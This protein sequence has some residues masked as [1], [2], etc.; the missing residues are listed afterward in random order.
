MW[1]GWFDLAAGIWLVISAFILSIQSDASII[2]AGAVAL[3]F[4]FWGATTEKSWQSVI[5]G[6]IG[7]W[8]LLSSI[9]FHLIAPWNFLIF[10]AIMGILAIWNITERPHAT[11]ITAH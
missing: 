6:I 10:G 8:L 1:Q 11:H 7:I 3:I 4:G 9:W 5:N 2:V